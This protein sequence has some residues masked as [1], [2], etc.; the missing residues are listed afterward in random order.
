MVREDSDGKYASVSRSERLRS[1]NARRSS[2]MPTRRPLEAD[3]KSWLN[4]GITL[5][6]VAPRMS[7]STGTS[8]QPR[9]VRPSSP[10][11]CSMWARVFATC[12]SSPGRK[13]VPTA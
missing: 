1:T 13:A 11:I 12:S 6:E 8:R 10:A 4:V 9:T 3:T 2:A 5:R 7:G